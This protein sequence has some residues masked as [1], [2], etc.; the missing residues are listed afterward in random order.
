M[1]NTVVHQALK[2]VC[3]VVVRAFK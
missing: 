1:H 2:A 3:N